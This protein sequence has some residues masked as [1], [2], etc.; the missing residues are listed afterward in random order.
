MGDHVQDCKQKREN[1]KMTVLLK[2][3]KKHRR[4]HDQINRLLCEWPLLVKPSR[5][6][7]DRVEWKEREAHHSLYVGLSHERGLKRACRSTLTTLANHRL[8]S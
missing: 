3:K 4:K 1:S 5:T 6:Y 2:K 7:Y 8:L